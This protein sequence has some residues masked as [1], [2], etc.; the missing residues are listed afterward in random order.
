MKHLKK[1]NESVYMEDDGDI[2]DSI[3]NGAAIVI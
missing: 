2:H 1:F 3:T